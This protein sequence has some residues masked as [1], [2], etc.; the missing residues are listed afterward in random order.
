[1]QSRVLQAI[2]E[3]LRPGG[4]LVVGKGE[5]VPP[6]VALDAYPDAVGIYART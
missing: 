1:V 6:S 4:V 3:R 2:L 5:A